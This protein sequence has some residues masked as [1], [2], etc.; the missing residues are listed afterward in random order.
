M[1]IDLVFPPVYSPHRMPYLSLPSLTGY[2]RESGYS[3]FQKDL[4]IEIYSKILQRAYIANVVDRLDSEAEPG[5]KYLESLL[6][7]APFVLEHIEDW[8]RI[9][10]SGEKEDFFKRRMALS[11]INLALEIVSYPC[12]PTRISMQGIGSRFLDGKLDSLFEGAVDKNENFFHSF[13]IDYAKKHI[14]GEIVGISVPAF[15]Q[16]LP[17]LTLSHVLKS[18]YPETCIIFGGSLIPYVTEVFS[19]RRF[20]AF[21]DGVCVG[22]GETPF[23]RMCENIEKGDDFFKEVPNLIFWNSSELNKSSLR[24]FED[25]NALPS[26]D[27]GGYDMEKYLLPGHILP[28]LTARG[29]YWNRCAF[30]SLCSSYSHKYRERKMEL[31]MEDIKEY[32]SKYGV[33]CVF[34]ADECI[35]PRRIEEFSDRLLSEGIDIGWLA[36]IR[37]EK[38]MNRK[39]LAKAKQAGCIGFSAGLE[40]AS[41]KILSLIDKGIDIKDAERILK[42]GSELGLWTNV[43]AIAGLPK[44]TPEDLMKT[45]DFVLKNPPDVFQI[46]PLR[47]ERGSRLYRDMKKFG[48][49]LTSKKEYYDYFNVGEYTLKDGMDPKTLETMLDWANCILSEQL[50]WDGHYSGLTDDTVLYLCKRFGKS[51]IRK[52]C[53]NSLSLYKKQKESINRIENDL[54][55]YI[56]LSDYVKCFGK[57][58]F[59]TLTGL[60]ISANNETAQYLIDAVRTPQQLS[61]IIERVYKKY[62][63]EISVEKD[64][65]EFYLTLAK[66]GFV[67]IVT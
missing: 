25:V 39:I 66:S 59:N 16:L 67:E 6:A 62:G 15:S 35:S 61:Q 7:S 28:L 26:P 8:K 57:R 22:E 45:I 1:R 34:F 40:S 50:F 63:R 48:I 38:G 53:M 37:F 46:G 12:R 47:L 21:V 41:Q 5:E 55:V 18:L 29:C 58:L 52:Y 30:C 51:F 13:F 2:L 33:E 9:M 19:D 44:E 64:V 32:I 27:W 60:S 49:E 17:A 24:S 36:L 14:E 43:F 54:S 31:V 42:E 20:A 4:N 65:R 3:V 56:K 23:L 11:G 10:K